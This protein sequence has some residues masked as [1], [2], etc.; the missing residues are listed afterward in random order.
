MGP[1]PPPSAFE[2]R[3]LPL[4]PGKVACAWPQ[5]ESGLCCGLQAPQAGFGGWHCQPR[6][7]PLMVA[8]CLLLQRNRTL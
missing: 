8:K 1:F 4:G 7:C 5:P 6:R 2:F 3:T